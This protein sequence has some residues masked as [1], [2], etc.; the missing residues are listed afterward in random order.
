M[1]EIEIHRKIRE[2]CEQAAQAKVFITDIRIYWLSINTVGMP[3]QNH[4][5][6]VLITTKTD[7]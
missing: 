3:V 1:E 2:I 6:E 4:L 7:Q 5:G